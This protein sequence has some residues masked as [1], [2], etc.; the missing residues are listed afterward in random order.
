[1]KAQA[2]S[3]AA[4]MFLAK[5][6]RVVSFL[7]RPSPEAPESSQTTWTD[8]NSKAYSVRRS[9]SRKWQSRG[10]RRGRLDRAR[11]AWLTSSPRGCC[12]FSATIRLG[13]MD[14]P[15]RLEGDPHY[16]SPER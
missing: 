13:H 12:I 14:E 8:R 15:S 3:R 10:G 6:P 2:P 1:M 11:D 5:L 16:H 4:S 7:I 9:E